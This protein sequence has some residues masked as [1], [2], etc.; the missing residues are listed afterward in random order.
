MVATPLLR[1][2]GFSRVTGISTIALLRLYDRE[3]I[4]PGRFDS[5]TSGSG[6]YRR[7]SLPTICKVAIA[8]KLKPLGLGIRQAL[9]DAAA[10]TD[11]GDSKRAANEL[12]E[13]GR[14]VLIHTATG[15]IIKNLPADASLSDALGRPMTPAIVL[16]IGPVIE[17]LDSKL[18][19]ETKRK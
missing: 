13:F 2:S 11:F 5:T 8:W 4:E 9:A 10:F 19:D 15:T 3:D 16:D 1:L 18:K 12:Y 6:D 14:T 7:Y 17:E